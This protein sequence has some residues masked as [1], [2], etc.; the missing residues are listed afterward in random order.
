MGGEGPVKLGTALLALAPRSR[1]PAFCGREVVIGS[2]RKVTVSK[3]KPQGVHS[4][5]Q[6]WKWTI[7]PLDDHFQSSNLESV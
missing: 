3:G 7:R 6:S 4:L 2:W 1:D 5:K